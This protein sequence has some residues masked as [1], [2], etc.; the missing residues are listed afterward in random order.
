MYQ[1]QCRC[2]SPNHG[3]PVPCPRPATENDDRCKPC[4]DAAAVEAGQVLNY[5]N[6]TLAA[7]TR[8]LAEQIRT[9]KII[10]ELKRRGVADDHCPRCG[11]FDWNV[12]FLEIIARPAVPRPPAIPR[13]PGLAGLVPSTYV[14]LP[15]AQPMPTGVIPV[16]CFVCKNCGFQIFHNSNV[17][18]TPR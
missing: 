13:P 1:T 4:H 10:E 11:V 16:V 7:Q 2:V 6:P 5:L 18:E 9:D 14:N 17:L 12:E 8:R 3:H 15:F